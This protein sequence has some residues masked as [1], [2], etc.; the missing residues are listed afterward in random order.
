[1]CLILWPSR[2][3]ATQPCLFNVVCSEPYACGLLI[4]TIWWWR[5]VPG[6]SCV[7]QS[8]YIMLGLT[9][10]YST[11][12]MLLWAVQKL[13]KFPFEVKYHCQQASWRESLTLTLFSCGSFQ[14]DPQKGLLCRRPGSQLSPV[15][16]AELSSMSS[17]GQLPKPRLRSAVCHN[18]SKRKNK[19]QVLTGF[20][21]WLTWNELTALMSQRGFKLFR[22]ACIKNSVMY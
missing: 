11:P 10:C 2:G 1:M 6:D 20:S 22:D 17:V 3:T 19:N 12:G 16:L 21:P 15:F 9:F 13:L 18:P 7:R 4:N 8:C 14:T 5:W